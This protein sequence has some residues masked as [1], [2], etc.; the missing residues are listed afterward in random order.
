MK[1]S[2][3]YIQIVS[4]KLNETGKLINLEFQVLVLNFLYFA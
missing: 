3:I 1:L 2:K 4:N